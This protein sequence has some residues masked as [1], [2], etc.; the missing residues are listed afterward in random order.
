MGFSFPKEFKEIYMTSLTIGAKHFDTNQID[1]KKAEKKHSSI[2]FKSLHHPSN[3]D[4]FPLT[5]SWEKFKG[6]WKKSSDELTVKIEE[7]TKG[8]INSWESQKSFLLLALE[9]TQY[10]S[11]HSSL[12]KIFGKLSEEHLIELLNEFIIN[13]CE[14][15]NVSLINRCL[16]L[17]SLDQM[18][19]I[20]KV[21]NKDFVSI[22]QT[23]ERMAKISEKLQKYQPD[24]TKHILHNEIKKQYPKFIRVISNFLNAL[25]AAFDVLEM[26]K[27]PGTY[28]ETKYLLDIYWK[29]LAIPV[30]VFQVVQQY[31][32]SPIKSLLVFSVGSVV[33][34]IAFYSY[35]K[36][37]QPSPDDL[38][39]CK[40][41]TREA[42][43]GNLS[44]IFG[45]EEEL[46]QL[47]LALAANG[48]N[49]RHHPLLYGKTG[50]GKTELVKGLAQRIVQ[51]NVPKSLK[52]KKVFLINSAELLKFIS[53]FD[54]KDPLDQ[55]VRKIGSNIIF[56]D[57]VHNVWN[58]P[59]GER[60]KTLLDTT[61]GSF[62]HCICATTE[63]EFEKYTNNQPLDRRYLLMHIKEM[64]DDQTVTILKNMLLRD[65]PEIDIEEN[66]QEN[67]LELI[68]KKTNE[69]MPNRSQ[70][71]KSK[72]ILGRVIAKIC[73]TQNAGSEEII[74]KNSQIETLLTDIARK[75]M[76]GHFLDSSQSLEF[77]KKLENLEI[78]MQA[79]KTSMEEKKKKFENYKFLKQLYTQQTKSM[80][81]ISKQIA[82]N[83]KE[84]AQIQKMFLFAQYFVQ[85]GIKKAIKNIAAKSNFH[86]TITNHLISSI[87]KDINSSKVV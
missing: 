42:E 8:K 17:I 6:Y 2:S 87:V 45:R 10:T 76:D 48:K 4:C 40:N 29:F 23:A 11:A 28:Y 79:I 69:L 54:L 25:V 53:P 5:K 84:N 18:L 43:I 71:D 85:P 68:V 46:N 27:E 73:E 80:F 78:E 72:L 86:L 3:C 82:N 75:N 38:P 60:L 22:K 77:L 62:K 31:F 63:S 83:K 65:A 19:K 50:V 74:K 41:L 52:G 36:W 9:N 57:E 55:I 24:D 49:N 7:I 56:F 35:F 51:G 14:K 70:P 30:I 1:L 32:I 64:K 58:H 47:V 66:P 12:K 39:Y 20:V 33:C 15:G 67:P 34:S 61:P 81:E 21:I 59:I 37:I 13:S 44:P 16:D 26:G